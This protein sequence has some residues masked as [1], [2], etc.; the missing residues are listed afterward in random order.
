M[1]FFAVMVLLSSL[2]YPIFVLAYLGRDGIL[3]W[4]FTFISYLLLF[5]RY[6][7]VVVMKKLRKV[8]IVMSIPFVAV[9]LMITIG[10]FV[11]GG[12]SGSVLYPILSYLGQ[13]PVNF[14]ELYD[15][16]VKNMGLGSNIFPLFF[17]STED[18]GYL[19]ERYDIKTWVF[20]TFVYTVYT[21]FGVVLTLLIGVILLLLF[22]TFYKN[23]KLKCNMSFSFLVLFGLFF[24]VYSQGVF[25]FRQ[26]N[27]VGNLF[28]VVMLLF[29][30]ISNF[31]PK[32]KFFL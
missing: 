4:F 8:A 18:V 13:G 17:A 30:F 28:I 24:T 14:A 15:T 5:Y 29:A 7:P 19:L 1:T 21:D 3:F 11:V 31:L 20:K 32:R 9:F 25:Y 6:L 12:S 27:R 16:G 10:R 26:Y 22:R 23:D 2:S